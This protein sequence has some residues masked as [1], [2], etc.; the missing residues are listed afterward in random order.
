MSPDAPLEIVARQIQML[1]RDQCI[2]QLLTFS[3][4]PLDF[5]PD[6]LAAMSTESLRHT[7]MAAIITVKRYHRPQARM[8]G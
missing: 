3:A 2:E 5:T 1:D 7:L 8:A 4:I 6:A